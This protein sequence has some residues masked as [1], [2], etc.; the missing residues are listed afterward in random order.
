MKIDEKY[1]K[2]NSLTKALGH[3][4]ATDLAVVTYYFSSLGNRCEKIMKNEWEWNFDI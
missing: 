2:P 1:K 3:K 4:A